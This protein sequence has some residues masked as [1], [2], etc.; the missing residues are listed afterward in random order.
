MTISKLNIQITVFGRVHGVGYRYSA[1][2]KARE[3]SITGFVKNQYDG[4]VFI[5]AEG[6]EENLDQFILWCQQGPSFA[7]VEKLSKTIGTLKGYSSF[8]VK[9]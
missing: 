2:H 3:L 5:E 1:L 6:Q 4:T 8:S 9:P 7:R